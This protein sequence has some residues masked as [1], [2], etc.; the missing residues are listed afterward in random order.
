M[1]NN[2][3]GYLAGS[4][5]YRGTSSAPSYGPKTNTEG[6]AE[7]DRKYR[8]T[9]A[10]NAALLARIKARQKQRFMSSESLSAQT[11]RTV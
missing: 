1:A 3:Y 7:R 6:Y 9:K 2:Q 4:K 8:V 11:G 10:R 5:T